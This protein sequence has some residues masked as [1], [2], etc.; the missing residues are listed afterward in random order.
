MLS[1]KQEQL[2]TL[3]NKKMTARV[4]P[5]GFSLGEV[6]QILKFILDFIFP[7]R[8]V[9]CDRITPH[10]RCE[11]ICAE[12]ANKIVLCENE[13]CCAVCGKPQVSVGEKRMCFPCLSKTHRSYKRAIAVV[14]YDK[15]VSE[16]IKRF[17]DGCNENAGNVMAKAMAERTKIEYAGMMPD[18]IVE[19]APDDKRNYKRGYS[20][21]SSICKKLSKYMNI[22]Y[23]SGV[24]L[25]I[26]N[27]PKQSSLNYEQRIRNLIGAIGISKKA[28]VEGKR[29]LL[30]DDVMTTGSTVEECA[31]VLKKAGAKAVFIV[32]YAT[33]VK[34]PKT[35]K[36][37]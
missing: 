11:E 8:C 16:G 1:E 12:C 22:P 23:E 4:K 29:V 31:Y 6:M 32:T 30:V 25:K 34:E 35:Y 27:T 5:C 18:V 28:D 15:L 21:V 37:K 9:F 3:N 33:T 14:K 36:N 24:L 2:I 7:Q 20:P 19:V 26:K 13:T 17:K 10:G